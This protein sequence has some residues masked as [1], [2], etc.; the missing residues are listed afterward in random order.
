MGAIM[1]N[2][3]APAKAGGQKGGSG[4][5]F[6]DVFAGG[7]RVSRY[8]FDPLSEGARPTPREETI[9]YPSHCV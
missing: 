1:A 7:S 2:G 6:A 5:A 4:D 8:V 9:V 3:R